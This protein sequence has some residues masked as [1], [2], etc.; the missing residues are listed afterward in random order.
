MFISKQQIIKEKIIQPNNF[1]IKELTNF[2]HTG[3]K[4]Y[5]IGTLLF[6]MQMINFNEKEDQLIVHI[7]NMLNKPT[8]INST[9]LF[10]LYNKKIY[11][12]KPRKNGLLSARIE[13]YELG[14]VIKIYGK[15]KKQ[16]LLLTT[17]FKRK[18][19]RRPF[20]E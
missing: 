4:K 20:Y 9:E 1:F 12:L 15:I 5:Q 17:Q 19:V 11:S 14:N 2:N 7:D 6:E 18:Q 8:F 3:E 13:K 10:V 16:N